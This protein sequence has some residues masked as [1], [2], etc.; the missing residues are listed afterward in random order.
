MASLDRDFITIK[1]RYCNRSV[2]YHNPFSIAKGGKHAPLNK[3]LYDTV[4]MHV[5]INLI[6]FIRR[7]NLSLT[8]LE[9][10]HS[11]KSYRVSLDQTG[12]H[13]LEKLHFHHSLT[14]SYVST[15]VPPTCFSG[16]NPN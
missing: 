9:K 7:P 3:I 2:T 10:G 13:T 15:A 6:H 8:C 16:I 1:K 12:P 11:T 14:D 4:L 5:H